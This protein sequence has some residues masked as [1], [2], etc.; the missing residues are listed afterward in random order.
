MK[1]SLVDSCSGGGNTTS[2]TRNSLVRKNTG[3]NRRRLGVGKEWTAS[4]GRFLGIGDSGSDS[5]SLSIQGCVS[6]SGF[7]TTSCREI[8]V[9]AGSSSRLRILRI[10][11]LIGMGAILFTFSALNLDSIDC[12][13]LAM[14]RRNRPESVDSSAYSSDFSEISSGKKGDK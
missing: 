13:V 7:D 10:V 5:M 6:T 4:R 12:G 11:E 2:T 1:F 14:L 9:F 3:F 8:G